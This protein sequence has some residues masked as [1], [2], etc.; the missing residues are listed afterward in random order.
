M[1]HAFRRMIRRV[2]WYPPFLGMGIR[3]ASHD[4]DFRE[5]VVELRPKWYTRNL[6]G[7][8]FGG[9][10][11]T[12]SDP[13]YV[14]IVTLNLGRDYIVWDRSANIEFLKPGVGVITGRF[15]ISSERL[16]E[17][18]AAV[19]AAGKQTFEFSTDLTNEAGEAVARITKTVYVRRKH[20]T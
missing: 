10:L 3:V 1:S 4:Q 20:K 8:A 9:S 17:M 12:M 13:F 5:F 7:T 15:A 18:R 14:F 2:N 16:D 19:D 6:F 11:Y